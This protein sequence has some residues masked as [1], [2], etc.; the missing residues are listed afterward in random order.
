MNLEISYLERKGVSTVR[1]LKFVS[2]GILIFLSVTL[3]GSEVNPLDY[4]LTLSFEGSLERA[5]AFGEKVVLSSSQDSAVDGKYSL[6]V[7]GRETVW[8]GCE[9]DLSEDASMMAGVEYE[10]SFHVRHTSDSP[11]LFSVLLRTVDEKGEKF[12]IV[13]EKVVMPNVWK[14]ITTTFMPSF[15]GSP[16]KLSL[17]IAA[18][19]DPKLAFY[20]DKVQ[21]L[22]PNKV[23]I[24]GLVYRTSFEEGTGDWQPRGEGVNL[25]ASKKVAHTGEYSMCVSDRQKS[26]NGAQMDVKNIL[27]TGRTYAFEAWVYQESGSDQRIIMTMQ[28]RYSTDAGTTRYEWIN[29]QTVPS[30]KWVRL[31]GTYTIPSGVAV[32]EL[33][34]YFE[35]SDPNLA[36]YVDDV[37]IADVNVPKF[38]PED[39]IPA[40]KDVY[41]D[42]F[43]IGVALPAKTLVNPLD[44]KL[45]VKHFNSITAENEMK[46]ESLLV[47]VEGGKLKFNFKQADEYVKF[48]Q[49]NGMVIRGHTLVWHSQTPEW[50][51]KDEAGNLLSK[52]KMIERMREYIHTVVGHF[53]GKVY[54]W[55]V[56]NEAIDPSQPDG[57]RRSLWYQ[58]IGPEYIELAFRFAHEADPDAK[59]FYNDYNTFEPKK[60]EFIYK[61][62]KELKE[63]GV[64]IHGVGIQGHV[65]VATDMKEEF[66]KAIQLFTSVPGIEI[67]VTEL[68]MSVYRDQTSNFPKAPREALI[69]QAYKYKEIFDMLMKY[70]D[71]VTN[72]TF[73]GLKDDYSWRATRRNDWTLIFDK[74]YQAKFAY[75]ALVAPEV[76]PVLPKNASATQGKATVVGMQDESYLTSKPIQ[77]F[78]NGEEKL[79]AWIIWDGN[80]IFIYGDVRDATKQPEKDAVAIFINPNN[81]RAPYLQ[82]DDVYVIL[83]QN[84][85]VVTNRDDVEVQRFIGPGYRKYSFECSITVPNITFQ[86]DQVIGF[87]IAVIDDGN[88]YSWCDTTNQQ[89]S[90]TMNYGTLKLEGLRLATA[91]Y[92]T[93]VIDAEIDDI[94]ET[95]EEIT[96]E[97]VVMGSLENAKAKVRV[98]WDENALYVLAI[99]T[100]PVLNKDNANP[101]EQDSFEIFIDENNAKTSSYQDDDAQYRVN[102]E[103][104]QSFGTG[105]SAARF[106]T[107][108]K[109]IQGGYIVEVAIQWKTIKPTPGTIIGF[110]VQVNDANARGQRVGILTWN[111]PVGNNWRDTSKFGNLKLVK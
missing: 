24:P 72:V 60:R 95:T 77:I 105:A 61:M 27:K 20:V 40:L 63:K 12:E 97:T 85:E 101:W 11:K 8:D 106:K 103:N 42:A 98:L 76:L 32:E 1:L 79:K 59:L 100:D 29:A 102:Y 7:E 110:D 39:E 93:P 52:E 41:K 104:F 73:W 17:V 81:A 4:A 91:K 48:A 47:G 66:E 51:F 45:I 14:K 28:R 36:F 21:V 99:V 57:Y 89:L 35:A 46:P 44:R 69:E 109:I 111:D 75:W 65:S 26:W 16:K 18:P 53:K 78:A 10:L 25:S 2:V 71:V 58:I 54:A 88:F 15:D 3:L 108:A 80:T 92:G 49:E 37:V 82:P 19:S 67:H 43:K 22:G 9:I 31:Y 84:W 6:K 86:K 56:V 70:K 74:D 87:D 5:V 50:F 38:E 107:A 83:K 62:V 33:V 30:G 23:Q 94:W 55:D 90:N 96:T 68:D 34:L 13:A 64:P